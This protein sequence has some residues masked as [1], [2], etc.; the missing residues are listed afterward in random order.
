MSLI[1]QV[2]IQKPGDP[3]TLVDV[4]TNHSG[5]NELFVSLKGHVC[6]EN[7]TTA[8][9]GAGGV[10]DGEWQDTLD[11]GIVVIGI[12]ADQNSA[13]DGLVIQWSADAATVHDTDVFTITAN[14]G[15]VFTFGPA[16]R[17]VKLN[18]TNGGTPQGS[19]SLETT[20]RRVYFKDS[21]HRIQD[22][23][24]A[25]DDASLVKAVLTG[26]NPG[27]N[28]VNFEA[29]N[30]GNFK[31]SLEEL[32]NAISD[33]GNSQLKTTRYDS[34]G[35][36]APSMDSVGRAGFQ[37]VT[38]GTEI[39][40]INADGSINT[41]PVAGSK[42]IITDGTDDAD[43]VTNA[44]DD[45]NLDGLNGLVTSNV[46]YG[47]I[48]AD[49]VKPIRIDASTHSI[50]TITYEHHE[51]HGG[52]HYFVGGVQDLS[53]NQVL[54]FTWQMP[55]TTKWIHWV[56]KLSTE[57]ETAWYIYENVTATNPLANS[58]TPYNSNR[59][60]ANTSATTMLY[61][62]QTNLA[63]ANTDTDVT[64]PAIL[65]DSGI[66]G[67]GKDSGNENRSDEIIMK[68]NTL[69]CLRAIASTAGYINFHMKWYEHTAKD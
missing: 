50:Q 9:L 27:G 31:V 61:E 45:T 64:A 29:T 51:I 15:K 18:Y 66:S 67:A 32:E 44:D 62:V 20:L 42:I 3:D 39:L 33:N 36:E 55:N 52:S 17:Y 12:N 48:D 60:S 10:F 38:D 47:R 8:T 37:Q 23:I 6:A 24:V 4:N 63:N 19:F 53:I 7:T 11:F 65:L 49:T 28:F 59:N 16:R 34:S 2:T 46:N 35:N 43:V 69:Y 41:T 26:E 56:W 21:S 14:Q 5:N 1:R 25:E 22:A 58:I 30:G 40:L 54:D 57:S 68:Q 13:N